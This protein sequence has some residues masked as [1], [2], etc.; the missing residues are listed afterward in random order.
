M[1]IRKGMHRSGSAALVVSILAATTTVVA[2]VEVATRGITGRVV[3]ESAHGHVRGRPDLDLDSSILVRVSDRG[4][5]D[6]GLAVTELEFIG[7][8]AGVFDLRESLVFDDG[9]SIQRLEP[10]PIEIVSNLASDAASDVF[11]AEAPP[12]SIV[13]GYRTLLGA[14][15]VAWILVPVVVGLRRWLHRPPVPPTPVMSRL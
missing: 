9:G 8:D 7:V 11:L 10:L 15:V 5:S 1:M 4:R 12:A 6:Q 3:V 14:I 2:D 13:G